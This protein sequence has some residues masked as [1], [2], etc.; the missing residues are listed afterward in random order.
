LKKE[1]KF[2]WINKCKEALQKLKNILIS[3]PIITLPVEGEEH[4][5]YNDASKDGL[6]G[7]LIQKDNFIPYA[8]R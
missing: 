8:L 3:S 2:E 7:V 6:E 4:T 1:I 5:I